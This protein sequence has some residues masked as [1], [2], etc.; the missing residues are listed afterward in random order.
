MFAF[1]KGS[2]DS[3]VQT[4]SCHRNKGVE[5]DIII[6]IS[7]NHVIVSVLNHVE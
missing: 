3:K 6:I 7:E 2:K 4:S 1:I 5:D